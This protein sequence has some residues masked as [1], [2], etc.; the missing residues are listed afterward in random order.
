[1]RTAE[2]FLGWRRENFNCCCKFSVVRTSTAAIGYGGG[3]NSKCVVVLGKSHSKFQRVRSKKR[4]KPWERERA[5]YLYALGRDKKT[6][7]KKKK[8]KKLFLIVCEKGG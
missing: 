8:K 7:K 6:E 5:M 4:K 3:D 1:M 2:K